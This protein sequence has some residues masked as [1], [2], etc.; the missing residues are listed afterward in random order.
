[1]PS[2]FDRASGQCP[3]LV[4]PALSEWPEF[5][6]C[7]PASTLY[8][9]VFLWIASSFRLGIANRPEILN[10]ALHDVDLMKCQDLAEHIRASD[11]VVL[12]TDNDATRYRLNELC[13]EIN[14]YEVWRV[15]GRW[16]GAEVK[17]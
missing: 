15:M 1:V 2:V 5:G 11:V 14:K 8:R 9:H 3:G 17:H 4:V 7:G 16:P 12:A 6:R 10:I 13:V